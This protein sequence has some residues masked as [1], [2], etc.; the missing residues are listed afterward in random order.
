[1]RRKLAAIVAGAAAIV[2]GVASPAFAHNGPAGYTTIWDGC[3]VGYCGAAWPLP[4]GSTNICRS[5]PTGA[6]DKPSAVDNYT[7]WIFDFYKD[8]GCTGTLYRIYAG[9]Q[10]GAL[11][12]GQG[13]NAWSSYKVHS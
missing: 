13:N 5:L 2:L 7:S 3:P 4:V 9:T 12:S 1:M 8:A 6:N 11:T 10:T